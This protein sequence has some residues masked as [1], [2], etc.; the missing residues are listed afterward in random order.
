MNIVLWIA[1]GLLAVGFLYSGWMKVQVERARASWPWAREVPQR[2]VIFI[3]LAELLGAVGT[4]VPQATG[5]APTLTPIAAACLAAIALL[6]A[7]LHIRRQEYK[8][9]GINIVF[10]ALAAFVA[11]G[12]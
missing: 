7:L 10:L 1:Q 3:G 11:L 5:I 12:R 4:I 2:L 8:D 9:I 6:G